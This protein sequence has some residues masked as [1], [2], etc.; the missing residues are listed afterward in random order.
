[1]GD[2][3]SLREA[4]DE[5]GLRL[6]L[7]RG[8]P[9][10]WSQAARAIFELKQVPFLKVERAARDS[11]GSLLEW[12]G[13]DSLPVA[14][15]DAERPRAGWAEIL[16]LAER[17]GPSPPLIPADP[18]QRAWMFGLAHE[19]LGE[20]GLVWCRRLL[21]LA[22]RL[23]DCPTDPE[24]VA[25]GYKYGSGP[26][27][28]GSAAQRVGDVLKLLAQQLRRQ[29]EAG[30]EF[31]VG[32]A[33]SAVDVYWAVSANLFSPLPEPL[34]PLPDG[35]RE[36]VLREAEPLRGALDPVL[37]EHQ[38]AIHRRFLRLPVEL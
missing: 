16:L 25:Y 32:D 12:T 28:V 38:H 29:R 5:P 17:L 19:I 2:W 9:S 18:E 10:P 31:L 23:R 6:V 3:L 20:M 24:V 27:E 34:L 4:R 36:H 22:P 15:Y 33:L 37:V 21:G 13:Q 11:P 8:F 14:A 1:M 35:V 26:A 30:R 7:L